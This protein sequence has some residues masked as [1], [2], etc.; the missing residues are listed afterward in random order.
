[1]NIRITDQADALTP[2]GRSFTEEKL[3][4]ALS[5]YIQILSDVS[6]V[7]T[8]A[9]EP[10]DSKHID[11]VLVITLQSGDKLKADIT[12]VTVNDALES[13]IQRI[14]RSL[15]RYRKAMFKSDQYYKNSVI[16]K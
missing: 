1:M 10:F 4:L 9:T 5:R 8:K 7:F 12:A 3:K 6:V 13:A 15:E 11:C 2:Q 14:K 16:E